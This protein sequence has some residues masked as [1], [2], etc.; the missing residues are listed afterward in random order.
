MVKELA[1]LLSYPLTPATS[2]GSN[3]QHTGSHLTSSVVDRIHSVDLTSIT[4][5]QI[6]PKPQM[7]TL[8]ITTTLRQALPLTQNEGRGQEVT[9]CVYIH[10]AHAQNSNMNLQ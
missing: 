3:P 10:T 6:S 1:T 2:T 5:A 7:V 8:P 4:V 9:G